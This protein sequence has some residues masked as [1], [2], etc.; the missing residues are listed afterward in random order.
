MLYFMSGMLLYLFG[1]KYNYMFLTLGIILSLYTIL[2]FFDQINFARITIYFLIPLL[3]FLIAF[4]VP[5][6]SVLSKYG[7]ISYG[8][9]IYAYP[10]QQLILHYN[11]KITIELFV[12]LSIVFTIPFA[13][14]SWHFVEKKSLKFKS[15]L[16]KRNLV[17][18]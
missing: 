6:I 11:P 10:I 16:S 14:F 18:E 12:I 15:V 9:Y 13:M 8:M 2:L 3:V 17:H 7:D 4:K 5:Q 1:R